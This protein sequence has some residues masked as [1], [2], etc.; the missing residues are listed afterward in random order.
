MVYCASVI[1]DWIRLSGLDLNEQERQADDEAMQTTR[2]WISAC[3]VGALLGTRED[4]S[5]PTEHCARWTDMGRWIRR[6]SR[7]RSS[8]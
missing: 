7:A 3:Q 6:S 4:R 8:R 1:R 2:E 5:N